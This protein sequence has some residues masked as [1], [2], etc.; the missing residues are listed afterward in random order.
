MGNGINAASER[1]ASYDID[2]LHLINKVITKRTVFV[3]ME[4][5]ITL[6]NG[7]GLFGGESTIGKF[8]EKV[9]ENFYKERHHYTVKSRTF[10]NHSS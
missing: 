7:N 10:L 3:P 8:I 4:T 5:E 2:S 6:V 1:N 9:N